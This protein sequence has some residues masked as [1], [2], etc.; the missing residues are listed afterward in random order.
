MSVGRPKADL[1]W[2][3]WLVAGKAALTLQRFQHGRSPQISTRTA[4]EMD[5]RN[6]C[7][8]LR[9]LPGEDLARD[10]IFVADVT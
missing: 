9:D 10:G 7:W 6:A 4:S 3:R 1:E 5:M 2:E 8:Q